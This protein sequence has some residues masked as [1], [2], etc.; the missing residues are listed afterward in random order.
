MALSRCMTVLLVTSIYCVLVGSYSSFANAQGPAIWITKI[1]PRGPGGSNQCS[2]ITG[3][4]R[5]TDQK[6]YI[7]V[8]YTYAGGKWW[9]QPRTNEWR[10][11]LNEKGQFSNYVHL[12]SRYAAFLVADSSF[13]APATS[14]TL[15]QMPGVVA[16]ANIAAGPSSSRPGEL[17]CPQP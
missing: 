17:W 7:V 12:G 11:G 13:D 9:I 3:G 8:L 1:P 14:E 10:S 5:T 16:V 2:F 6:H 4:V 15:P